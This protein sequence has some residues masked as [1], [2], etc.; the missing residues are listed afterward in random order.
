[1]EAKNNISSSRAPAAAAAG[2]KN[3]CKFDER[4]AADN[5]E[6]ETENLFGWILQCKRN[7]DGHLVLGW[8]SPHAPT[9]VTQEEA[10]LRGKLIRWGKKERGMM[11]SQPDWRKSEVRELCNKY[12]VPL[13]QALS[14]R[15]HHL[16]QLNIGQPMTAL[17][18]GKVNDINESARLFEKAISDFLVDR[19]ITFFSEGEQKSF[20][21]KN[22]DG[23]PYPPTPDFLL[24]SEI[25]IEKYYTKTRG[26]KKRNRSDETNEKHIIRREKICW[27]EVKMFYGASTIKHDN[28]SAVGCLL[29]TA[30]KY[31]K[32]FGPGAMVFM[33]GCGDRLEHE[34]ER[35]GVLVL[36]CSGDMFSLQNVSAHQRTWCADEHGEILP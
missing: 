32:F 2:P 36:D 16:K 26:K 14:L 1:M 9:P 12:R 13:R 7:D 8:Y 11:N 25:I 29:S 31:T 24:R 20:I 33:Q 4:T 19:G 10:L 35:E 15:R 6:S 22:R 5:Q 28:K 18:L 23:R 30:R 17:G 3:N 34:L 21:Q 27:I